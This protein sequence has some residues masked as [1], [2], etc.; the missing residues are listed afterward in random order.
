MIPKIHFDRKAC[1]EIPMYVL[2]RRRFLAPFSP[3]YPNQAEE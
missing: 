3:M 1:D 2:N